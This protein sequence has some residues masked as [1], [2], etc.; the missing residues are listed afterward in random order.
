MGGAPLLRSFV[1]VIFGGLGSVPGAIVG[2]LTI[3]LVENLA[4]AYIS[5]AFKDV[6]TFALLIAVLVVRPSGLFGR[7]R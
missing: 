1:I 6:F 2:G 5:F 4:G 3:G 7:T